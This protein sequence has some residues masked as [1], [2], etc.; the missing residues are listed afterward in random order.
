MY[1]DVIFFFT[2]SSTENKENLSETEGQDEIRK[3]AYILLQIIS[4]NNEMFEI[5]IYVYNAF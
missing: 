4:L 3:L 2:D 5:N 1:D